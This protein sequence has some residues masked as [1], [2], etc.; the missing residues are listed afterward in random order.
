M[1]IIFFNWVD[2]NYNKYFS[3]SKIFRQAFYYEITKECGNQFLKTIG[4]IIHICKTF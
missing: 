4:D 1:V 2:M 3:L